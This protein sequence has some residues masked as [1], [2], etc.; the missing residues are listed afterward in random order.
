MHKC[1]GL[2][3]IYPWLML[4]MYML[5]LCVYSWYNHPSIHMPNHCWCAWDIRYNLYQYMCNVIVFYKLINLHWLRSFII[6]VYLMLHRFYYLYKD[7]WHSNTQKY[8]YFN[9]IVGTLVQNHF[10]YA[11]FIADYTALPPFIMLPLVWDADYNLES[12]VC[13][14][15]FYCMISVQAVLIRPTSCQSD[16]NDLHRHAAP[17]IPSITLQ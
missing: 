8:Y 7:T 4:C 12:R 13:A 16:L 10:F 17:K 11:M 6:L 5:L 1:Q 3:H 9:C 14:V 15:W 2:Y